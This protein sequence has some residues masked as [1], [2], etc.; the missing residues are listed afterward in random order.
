L[1]I[2]EAISLVVSIDNALNA[3]EKIISEINKLDIK[4]KILLLRVCGELEQGKSSDIKF[5]QIEEFAKNKG[6]YF[7]LK[8]VYDLRTKEIELE[9]NSEEVENMEEELIILYSEQNVSGFNSFI[10]QIMNSLSVEKQ[11]DER[12][13]SFDA[14]L[15]DDIKKILKF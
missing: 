4:D 6:V 9:I 12:V 5:S 10:S 2:K 8:N 15:I 14:R 7:L 11:E 13:E 3:T 1:K